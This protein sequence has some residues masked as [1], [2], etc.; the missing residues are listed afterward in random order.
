MR[1]AP[2]PLSLLIPTPLPHTT[3]IIQLDGTLHSLALPCS[4]L[5]RTLSASYD[6]HVCVNE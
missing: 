5:N 3:L 1:A 4:L 6:V 2:L